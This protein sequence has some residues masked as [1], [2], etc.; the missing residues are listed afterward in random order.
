MNGR[1]GDGKGTIGT[2]LI[3]SLTT[4]SPMPDGHRADPVNC[5]V[6]SLEDDTERTVIP[7]LRAAGADLS[8]VFIL[9][10]I[11]A[12]DENGEEFRRPWSMPLDLDALQ[13]FITVNEVRLVCARPRCLHDRAS[14]RQR[15]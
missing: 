10:G 9:D 5:A 12:T 1:Q 4:G 8:H 11:N 7:R 6:L 2:S 14:G 13:A 15:I 3:G